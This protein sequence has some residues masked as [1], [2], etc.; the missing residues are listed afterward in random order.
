MTA[1]LVVAALA[2]AY[3]S[4]APPAGLTGL[5]DGASPASPG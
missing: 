4:R 1:A 3:S 5:T 2:A